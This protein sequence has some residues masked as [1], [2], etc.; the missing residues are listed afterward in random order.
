M[1]E[2]KKIENLSNESLENVNGGVVIQNEDGSVTVISGTDLNRPKWG[3]I[4]PEKLK[5]ALG[6]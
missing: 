2:E 4:D 5:E 1:S 3:E 6:K